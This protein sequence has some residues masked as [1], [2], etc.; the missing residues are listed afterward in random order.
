[1]HSHLR[2]HGTD[3]GGSRP[4][5]RYLGGQDPA[6]RTRHARPCPEGAENARRALRQFHAGR[7]AGRFAA[8]GTDGTEPPTGALPLILPVIRS[9]ATT[10]FLSPTTSFQSLPAP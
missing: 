9:A 4:P 2:R 8:E 7:V 6:D 3:H 5:D 1:G 10:Q